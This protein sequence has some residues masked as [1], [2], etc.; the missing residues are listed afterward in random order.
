MCMEKQHG[1]M[2]YVKA[3]RRNLTLVR[4]TDY[5]K[6]TLLGGRGDGMLPQ[7]ILNVDSLRLILVG[8]INYGMAYEGSIFRT[9]M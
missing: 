4:P 1:L 5:A 9:K 2:G 8:L 3:G 7:E 6:H